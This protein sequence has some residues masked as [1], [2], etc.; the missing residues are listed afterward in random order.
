M[1]FSVSLLILSVCFK[2]ATS[3]PPFTN[4]TD[5]PTSDANPA[6][7]AEPENATDVSLFCHVVRNGSGTRFNFWRITIDSV[8]SFLT[9]NS[10]TGE[11]RPGSENFF[12]TFQT[13]G[14]IRVPSNLTIRVFTKSLDMANISC[15][16]GPDIAVNGTFKLRII[17]K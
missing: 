17:S 10:T 4:V 1:S 11:G 15:G 2:G 16:S 5:P 8:T 14:G 13:L 3:Q 6:V 7:I 9:F 12:V